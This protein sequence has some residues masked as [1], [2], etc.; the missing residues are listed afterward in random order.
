MQDTMSFLKRSVWKTNTQYY[1][2]LRERERTESPEFRSG[3]EHQ[4]QECPVDSRSLRWLEMTRRRY[5]RPDVV[6]TEVACGPTWSKGRRRWLS[7]FSGVRRALM[8][9]EI[10]RKGRE[11]ADLVCQNKSEVC[12]GP[13]MLAGDLIGLVSGRWWLRE[14]WT[15]VTKQ[16]QKFLH[17]PRFVGEHR[18]VEVDW[19]TKDGVVF[20]ERDRDETDEREGRGG[21]CWSTM[22]EGRT[23]SDTM[24]V[25][26]EMENWRILLNFWMNKPRLLH[27]L[28]RR[29][30]NAKKENIKPEK[31]KITRA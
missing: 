28:N 11:V 20:G 10:R 15:G 26:W 6:Y 30:P 24:W 22:A 13:G 23:S 16:T 1:F 9:S 27:R 29:K 8:M 17:Y 25:F 2:K 5:Q 21:R 31:E 3:L 7:E 14:H 19:S 18:E 4:N 12:R